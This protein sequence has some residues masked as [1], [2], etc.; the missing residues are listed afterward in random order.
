M[1]NL[2]FKQAMAAHGIRVVQTPVGDRYVLEAMLREGICLGGE[3]SGHLVFFDHATTGDGILT[4][5]HLLAQVAMS[6]RP[7]AELAGVMRRLPQVLLNVTVTDRETAAGSAGLAAVVAEIEEELGD[8]GR[9]LVR[10]SG[11]EPV[12][13]IMVEADSSEQARRCAE[14]IAAAVV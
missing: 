13:R 7:L 3:Q 5:L 11:T 6:R 14:R 10:P 2:G 12:V 4:S 1:T 8:T 9:V